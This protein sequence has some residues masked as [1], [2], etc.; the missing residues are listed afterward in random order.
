MTEQK[1]SDFRKRAKE[2]NDDFES[3]I[4][5]SE[6]Y[7][8]LKAKKDAGE[9]LTG[10]ESDLYHKFLQA[11]LTSQLLKM[12]P[13]ARKMAMG[14]SNNDRN[15]YHKKEP[16]NILFWIAIIWIL[17]IVIAGYLGVL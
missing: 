8:K 16:P 15:S 9:K 12:S 14:M 11:D 5:E 7:K 6:I 10:E 2:L 4:S 3:L 13:E 17:V 1:D